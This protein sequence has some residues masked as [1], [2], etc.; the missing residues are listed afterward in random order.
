MVRKGVLVLAPVLSTTYSDETNATARSIFSAAAFVAIGRVYAGELVQGCEPA[1]GLSPSVAYERR[2][3][4]ALVLFSMPKQARPCQH[5]RRRRHGQYCE[6]FSRAVTAPGNH[7]MQRGRRNTRPPSAHES[8]NI[9]CQS[10]ASVIKCKTMSRDRFEPA[11]RRQIPLLPRDFKRSCAGTPGLGVH[12]HLSEASQ[13]GC[14]R[15]F[16]P[17]AFRFG[18]F[19][20]R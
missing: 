17:A 9:I 12:L 14:S 2:G 13:R 10:K 19:S 20:T 8:C 4:G 18:S 15:P 1:P 7:T 5:Q 11:I 6:A 16:C 3:R